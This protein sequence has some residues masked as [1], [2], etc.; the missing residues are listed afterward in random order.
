MLLS[1]V[2]DEWYQGSV[3]SSAQGMFPASF[4]RIEVP[5]TASSEY[6]AVALYAFQAETGEDLSLQV[7]YTMSHTIHFRVF[8]PIDPYCRQETLFK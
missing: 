3:G 1:Q 5:L 4:V 2:N 6:R 8:T 7:Q